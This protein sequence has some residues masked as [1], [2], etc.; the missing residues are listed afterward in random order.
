MPKQDNFDELFP[1]AFYDDLHSDFGINFQMNRC[2]NF[3]NDEEMLVEMR[4]VS[5][6]IHNYS[7]FIA[8]FLKLYE[9]SLEGGHKLRAAHYLRTAE[10]YMKV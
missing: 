6:L 8:E 10:F 2:Y 7:E 5:P 9:K 4:A 3:T 1:V